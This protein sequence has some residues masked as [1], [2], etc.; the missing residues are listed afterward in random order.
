MQDIKYFQV[1]F[2]CDIVLSMVIFNVHGQA[3]RGIFTWHAPLYTLNE[4]LLKS[5]SLV[6]LF[7]FGVVCHT[8]NVREE[9]GCGRNQDVE[10]DV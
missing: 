9:V 4:H 10:M 6:Y 7:V 2:T 1:P 8:I 5:Y 3:D